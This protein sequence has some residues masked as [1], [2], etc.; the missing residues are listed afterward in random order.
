MC[1]CF[2][3]LIHVAYLV[4][5]KKSR[6]PVNPEDDVAVSVLN[7]MEKT[8][9]IRNITTLTKEML[10]RQQLIKLLEDVMLKTTGNK[11]IL[12]QRLQDYYHSIQVA[13]GQGVEPKSEHGAGKKKTEQAAE[14]KKAGKGADKKLEHGTGKKKAE[15][16][17][18]KKK[19]AQQ[20]AEKAGQGAEEKKARQGVEKESEQGLVTEKKVEQDAGQK[21]SVIRSILLDGSK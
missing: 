9:F 10:T 3:L 6:K 2:Y 14:E 18:G 11:E 1:V 12:L 21:V 8:E 19:A 16:G 5:N 15:H 13:A 17:A 20:G 7:E 4:G